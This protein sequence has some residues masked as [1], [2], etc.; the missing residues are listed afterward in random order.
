M[1][2]AFDYYF[3][4]LIVCFD[5]YL[6]ICLDLE[7]KVN[8]PQFSS[9]YFLSI[10]SSSDLLVGLYFDTIAPSFLSSQPGTV[11]K[12]TLP[13]ISEKNVENYPDSYKLNVGGVNKLVAW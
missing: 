3:N 1:N 5:F 8:T 4:G 13:I 10:L 2:E 9:N 7:T 12:T 11:E 6:Y